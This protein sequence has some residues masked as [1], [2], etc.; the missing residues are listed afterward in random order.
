MTT[1]VRNPYTGLP[2]VTGSGSGGGAVDSV[3][4]ADGTLVISPTTGVVVASL[5]LNQANTWT[6]DQSVPAD[7]YGAGWNGSNEVP[8]KNDVYD[9]IQALP[10]P[11]VSFGTVAVSG[12]SDVI[13]N[14]GS[15]TLNIAAGAN[16]TITTNAGT[17]TVT[18]AASGGGI[19]DGDKGDI[20]VSSS[21][22]VWTI[23]Q[24]AVT[25]AKAASDLKNY[26]IAMA[27]AL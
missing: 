22:T 5:N 15:A 8:T 9:A 13:A 12:Q 7:P 21:G 10:S 3:S 26:V 2:D 20:T 6:A 11:G 4:N 27:A 23:D 19:S 14:T 17:D 25:L 16:V 18:I 1:I 24:N